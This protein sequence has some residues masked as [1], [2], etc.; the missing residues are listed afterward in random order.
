M[1]ASI[2]P[3]SADAVDL[4]RLLVAMNQARRLRWAAVTT[5]VAVALSVIAGGGAPMGLWTAVECWR[6]G[7]SWSD[8]GNRE[9]ACALLVQPLHG[10]LVQP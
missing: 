7:W 2:A 8:L 10:L 9:Q 5:R 1:M 3:L 6:M 4:T